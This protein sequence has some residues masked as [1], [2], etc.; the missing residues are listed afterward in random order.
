MLVKILVIAV[1]FLLYS[2]ATCRKFLYN[3]MHTEEVSLSTVVVS[4]LAASLIPRLLTLHD[5]VL[6][7]D[8]RPNEI[9]VVTT[10]TTKLCMWTL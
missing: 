3:D 10:I 7:C 8:N 9:T 4:A 1:V 2:T 6:I 5:R